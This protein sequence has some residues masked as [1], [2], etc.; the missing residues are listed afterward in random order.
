MHP[1]YR[2][3]CDAA[4]TRLRIKTAAGIPPGLSRAL[5]GGGSFGAATGAL[6]APEG[7]SM[8]GAM[9]GAVMGGGGAALGHTIG[10]GVFRGSK[11]RLDAAKA[12][13]QAHGERSRLDMADPLLSDPAGTAANRMGRLKGLEEKA[14]AGAA[15]NI[16]GSAMLGGVI[17][18][19]V[20]N[21]STNKS[22]LPQTQ[23]PY[24][25]PTR[26]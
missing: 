10:K 6:A 22:P 2:Q 14:Q 11:G 12:K 8:E 16:R 1:A 5:I 15:K 23:N 3:G 21:D 18:A 19:G 26:R 20:A 7:K 17:G 4:L 13:T 25:Y 9:R 24:N